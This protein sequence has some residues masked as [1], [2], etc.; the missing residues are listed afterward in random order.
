MYL[1]TGRW[2]QVDAL[3]ARALERPAPER[4]AFL[5]EATGGDTELLGQVV[6][7]LDS[8]DPAEQEIGEAAALLL[9]PDAAEATGADQPASLAVGTRLGAYQVVREIGRGGMGTVY[10]AER[11]D[12]AFDRQVAIKLLQ[13]AGRGTAW[14]RRFAAEQRILAGLEHPNIARLY[15]A[16]LEDD[17]PFLVMEYV[18]GTRIDRHAS[19]QGLGLRQRVGLLIAVCDAV[20]YAHQRLVVHRDLKPGNVLVTP[21]G[22]VKL[23]DFGIAQLVGPSEEG[24]ATRSARRMLTPEY[25]APEQV[26]GEPVTGG[27]DVYSLGVMLHELLTGERPPWQ[28]LVVREAP[29]ADVEA[30][31]VP[32]SRNGRRDLRGDLDTIVL[33]ALAPDPARRYG[34]VQS[35]RDDLRAYLDGLAIAARPATPAYRARKFVRRNRAL[36]AIGGL[37]LLLGLGYTATVVVQSRR[38]EA[39]RDRAQAERRR[40][41]QVSN[42]LV[43]L[44]KTGDPFAP[45]RRDTMRVIQFLEQ[46]VARVDAELA[47]EP[48][49]RARLLTALGGVFRWR[50]E[51]DRA[52][53]VLAAA[54][55][56]Y[57]D[58]PDRSPDDLAEA[59]TELGNVRRLVGQVAA[60]ESLHREALAARSEAFARARTARRAD[61]DPRLLAASLANLGAVLIE[62]NRLDA[63][64]P[65]IDSALALQRRRPVLDS[66]AVAEILNYRAAV[67]FRRGDE[68]TAL[69]VVQESYELNRAR[70]GPDHPRV[71]LELANIAVLQGRAGQWAAAE[72]ALTEV[73]RTYTTR[74]APDHPQRVRNVANLAA[75]KGNLGKLGEADS[76]LRW[77]IDIDRQGGAEHQAHLPTAL[78]MHADLLHRA[79][80]AGEAVPLLREAIALQRAQFPAG[81]PG[82]ASTEVKLAAARCAL[83]TEADRRGALAD[84]E[85]ARQA[86]DAALPPEHPD[87]I[88][89]RGRHGDCLWR[90][91]R[92]AEGQAH[93]EASREEAGR[94]L[95]PE[96]PLTRAVE[97]WLEEHRGRARG[98]A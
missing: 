32:P 19:E 52:A 40:A 35:L 16:G 17:Q 96:H 12:R 50:G 82:L 5:E 66:A 69:A 46:G 47:G 92:T 24:D 70:L 89:A 29:T 98:P 22:E 33:T 84:L 62:Q 45:G 57:R 77:V 72:A 42:L 41:E 15:D 3:F 26:R 9:P 75:V 31:M 44:F 25:A 38:L 49:A 7:L 68:R 85:R 74:L 2:Q 21:A 64:A 95:G 34:S 76:L 67:A 23:L 18:A 43:G 91:G 6:A 90:S 10:L 4:R 93:L 30:A 36:V 56:L 58:Q 65:L 79:G 51:T 86:L 13:D 55:D 11:A 63:A 61:A 1:P 94:R 20:S 14:R 60:A 39:E 80:R 71:A 88:A 53:Q 48:L 54:I 83:P 81:H 27:A 8:L 73:H 28:R 87:R 97:R 78:D 59:L 37:A